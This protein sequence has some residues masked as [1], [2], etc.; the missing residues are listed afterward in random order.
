VRIA[1]LLIRSLRGSG[2]ATRISAMLK[3]YAAIGHEVEVFHYRFAHEEELPSTVA[4]LVHRYVAIRLERCRYRQHAA[5]LPPL[6]WHC[7][8]ARSKSTASTSPYDV[9]Q[10]ETSNT[11]GIARILPAVKRLAVLH[12]D[13]S[14]RLM[15]L[16]KI[17]TGRARRVSTEVAARKYALWQRTVIAEADRIWFVSGVERDRLASTIPPIRTRVI[18]NGVDDELW[19][20]PLLADR[21]QSAVLF[22]GPGFY[23]A[24][25]SGLAWFMAEVWPLVKQ[26]VSG[27]HIRIVGVGWERFEPH[28]DAS[29]VGWRELLVDEYSGARVIIA[30]LFA[31][32]G[33]KLKILEAMAA[34]RPVVTTPLGAEG[35]PPSQGM[36]V[37]SDRYAF[38]SEV[39]RFLTDAGSASTAGAANRSAVEQFKWSVVWGRAASDLTELVGRSS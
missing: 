34:A 24:N 14:A 26:R 37:C 32:G 5:L 28:P 25:S 12:D 27:A 39:I 1:V 38:A 23:E 17:A 10:A 7:T 36:R 33:T 13:D 35:L 4:S 6:A 8:R 11:W 3:S 19:S 21:S 15:R 22:V 30:P 18:P 16:A 31:G 2:F 20:I 29:F 9:V